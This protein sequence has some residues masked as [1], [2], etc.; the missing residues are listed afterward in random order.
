MSSLTGRRGWATVVSLTAVLGGLVTAQLPLASASATPAAVVRAATGAADVDGVRL[1]RRPTALTR[2]AVRPVVARTVPLEAAPVRPAAVP[3]R[4][5]APLVS[6]AQLKLN[7]PALRLVKLK[8]T[9]KP[10]E[11]AVAVVPVASSAM[12]GCVMPVTAT[13]FF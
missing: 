8:N 11:R 4:V 5:P 2:A 12:E 3:V 1:S 7:V 10:V 9:S 6:C 13:T